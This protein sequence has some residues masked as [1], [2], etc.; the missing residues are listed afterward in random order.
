MS[1]PYAG[2]VS[3]CVSRCEEA[4]G[5]VGRAAAIARVL[6]PA[7]HAVV[8]VVEDQY[9]AQYRMEAARPVLCAQSRAERSLDALAATL[10]ADGPCEDAGA[11]SLSGRLLAAV[12]DELTISLDIDS[13]ADYRC[14]AWDQALQD[15]HEVVDRM[16]AL[17]LHVAGESEC[18]TGA[19]GGRA[20]DLCAEGAAQ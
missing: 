4:A 3:G 17:A 16:A 20:V 13:S 14:R 5:D 1:N 12:C 18:G 8:D 6:S 7:A 10:Q 15:L 9:G 11:W 19:C 2:E